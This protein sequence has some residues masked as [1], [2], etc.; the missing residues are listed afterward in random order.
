MKGKEKLKQFLFEH[1]MRQDHL[2]KKLKIST[3]RLWSL[4]TK[5]T[6]KPSLELAVRIEE[7]T[8]TYNKEDYIK[9]GDWLIN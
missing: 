9:V 3:Q 5:P 8:K 1:G 6:S 4:L 2:A 7:L